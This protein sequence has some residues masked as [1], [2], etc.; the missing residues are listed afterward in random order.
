VIANPEVDIAVAWH[1]LPKYGA[2]LLRSVHEQHY[3]RLNII[4]TPGPSERSEIDK[5]LGAPAR[6]IDGDQAVSWQ[7]IRLPIPRVFISSGWAYRAFNCLAAETRAHGGHVVSMIDNSKKKTLRQLIGNVYFRA[8]VRRRIDFAWVPGA[9]ARLLLEGYGFPS[10]RIYEGL[11]GAD[12]STFLPGPALSAR[13]KQFVFVGQFIERKAPVVLAEA[14]E[15]LREKMPEWTL[16]MIGDGP[17][18]NRLLGRNRIRVLPFSD[19]VEVASIMAQSR[20]LVLP[21]LE[22][23]WPLVVHEAVSSGCGVIISD[24]VGSRY[25][26]ATCRNSLI[27]PPN[28]REALARALCAAALM[29]DQRLAWAYE[30]SLSMALQFGPCRFSQAFRDLV[31]SATAMNRQRA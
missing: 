12:T 26:L 11:Y 2:R 31:A 22:D 4:G 8:K 10:N 1:G 24:R 25:E 18:R 17:L 6:W 28:D 14:F 7:A 19:S 5:E 3:G 29:D 20:F 9:S 21:S 27:I 13:P 15:R 16:C 23:H 30:D